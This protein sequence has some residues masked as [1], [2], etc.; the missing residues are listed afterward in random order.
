[1]ID[2]DNFKQVNDTY[3]HKAGDDFLQEFA[4]LLK[5][6]FSNDLVVRYGG[7]EFTIVS[8]QPS[9]KYYSALS[10][11]MNTVRQTVFTPHKLNITCSIG[12]SSETHPSLE[13]QLETADARLYTAKNT[14]KNRIITQD[15]SQKVS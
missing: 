4:S 12:V 6:Y 5:K 10:E 13:A 9:E 11:F 15:I 7:E 2:A 14:G 3:G 1:M 8:T